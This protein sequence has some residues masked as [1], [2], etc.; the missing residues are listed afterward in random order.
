MKIVGAHRVT[1][2]HITVEDAQMGEGDGT[3]YLIDLTTIESQWSATLRRGT[4][5]GVV[6]RDV[7]VLAGKK[8]GMRIWSNDESSRIDNVQI[9]GLNILGEA[10]MGFDQIAYEVSPYNGENIVLDQ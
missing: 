10:V 2:E 3:P 1:F 7:S 9:S 8:P 4:I 5:D 6:I